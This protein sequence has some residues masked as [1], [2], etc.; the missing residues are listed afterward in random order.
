MS[1]H[2][3]SGKGTGR[4]MLQEEKMTKLIGWFVKAA[5]RHA[6]AIEALEDGLA[7]AQMQDLNRYYSALQREGGVERF[8]ELLDHEDPNVAGMAAV[9]AMRA[10]PE[11]CSAA[12]VRVSKLPGL[13]GFRAQAALDRWERGEWPQ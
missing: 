2:N 9:Y 7:A 3:D 5:L 11:R 13:I 4:R 6:E 8:L 1:A 10:A 12:L